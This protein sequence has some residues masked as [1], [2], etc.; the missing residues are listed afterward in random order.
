MASRSSTGPGES[1]TVTVVVAAA[2]VAT[3][4]VTVTVIVRGVVLGLVEVLLKL[5]ARIAVW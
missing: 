4:S 2:E 1:V 5:T 3:P